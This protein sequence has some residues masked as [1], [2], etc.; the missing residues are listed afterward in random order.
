MGGSEA[1]DRIKDIDESVMVLLSSGY[2]IEGQAKEIMDRGCQGFIQKP[3]SI[4]DLSIKVR[5]ALDEAKG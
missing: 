2:S 5:E 3:F 4:N 1:Y